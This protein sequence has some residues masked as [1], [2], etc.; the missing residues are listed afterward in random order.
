MN[1][2]PSVEP[3]SETINHQDA[4]YDVF[5]SYSSKDRHLV[6]PIICALR[7]NH[8]T[9]F[10]LQAGMTISKAI[11]SSTI[12]MPII[13]ENFVRSHYCL[14]ELKFGCLQSTNRSKIVSPVLFDRAVI[15]NYK[16]LFFIKVYQWLLLEEDSSYVERIVERIY[17]LVNE[18]CSS[19]ANYEK[20]SEYIAYGIS[21]KATEKL[22]DLIVKT[23]R[24]IN[25]YTLNNQNILVNIAGQNLISYLEKLANLPNEPYGQRARELAR[26]KLAALGAV[27]SI[28]GVFKKN[29][30]YSI[31][32]IIR[33]IYWDRIIRYDSADAIT[34]GDVL[35]G[36]V[37]PNLDEEKYAKMQA[38]FVDVYR[39]LLVGDTSRFSVSEMQFI[40]STEEYIYNRRKAASLDSAPETK[41][42]QLL[43]SVANFTKESNKLFDI[44]SREKPAKD[45]LRCLI[46]SYNRLKEYCVIV[47]AKD[48]CAECIDRIS[49]L[50]Q[51]LDRL[52]PPSAP[53][54]SKAEA[55]IKSL[56]GIANPH[57]GKYDVFLSHK[58]DDYDITLDIYNF[59]KSNL[60]Q[61]FL[62]KKSLP[63][64]SESDYRKA[65]MK[66]L[67]GSQH[68]VVV[69]SNLDYLKSEWVELEMEIFKSEQDEGRKPNSNF[70]IVVTED[71]YLQ[72]IKSNKAVLPIEY[73]RCEIIKLQDYQNVLL[74]YL[75]K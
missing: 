32:I 60:K 28:Q 9:V 34:G 23:C 59:L 11:S 63:E 12:F 71:V 50:Q 27:S 3:N 46:M 37:N 73:R 16:E 48:I 17:K 43:Q 56:L 24:N 31:S 64:M 75:N 45:F 57:S 25:E 14:D 6:D 5:I 41:D 51:Q 58:S 68:F 21:D 7:E 1:D 44:I 70:L 53:P 67:D 55:G 35:D 38:E 65:I 2:H 29:N 18:A 20:L 10:E 49:E 66:A 8:I 72:I 54:Y 13:T 47:G 36:T 40:T 74:N 26:K 69:L 62:D 30:L 61:A 19:N 52:D 42:S 15:D 33:I 22:C 39:K 4:L